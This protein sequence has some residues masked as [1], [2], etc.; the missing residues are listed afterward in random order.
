MAAR[1]WLSLLS[2]TG[3]AGAGTFLLSLMEKR[4]SF[5]DGGGAMP[6]R[7]KTIETAQRDGVSPLLLPIRSPLLKP[8]ISRLGLGQGEGY[9]RRH[10]GEI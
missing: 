10:L 9:L 3:E 2:I 8:L 5:Q 4:E 1:H 6:V 7:W